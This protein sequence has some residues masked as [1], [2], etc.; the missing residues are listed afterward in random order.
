[1]WKLDSLIAP[2]SNMRINN[3]EWNYWGYYQHK[4][5]MAKKLIDSTIS[6]MLVGDPFSPISQYHIHTWIALSQKI[7][8]AYVIILGVIAIYLLSVKTLQ[9]N[10]HDIAIHVCCRDCV[11]R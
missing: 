11:P 4:G 2:H 10:L 7:F 6:N 8:P 9:E 1:M 5:H 3:I